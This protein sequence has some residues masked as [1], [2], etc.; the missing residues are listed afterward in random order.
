MYSTAKVLEQKITAVISSPQEAIALVSISKKNEI[1]NVILCGYIDY[2][3]KEYI[4]HVT[5]SILEKIPNI[6]IISINLYLN[7][8][9]NNNNIKDVLKKIIY[10]Y[11]KIKE[12]DSIYFNNLLYVDGL[13]AG[14]IHCPILERSSNRG[15]LKIIEHS[16][17]DARVQNQSNIKKKD[18]K[19]TKLIDKLIMSKRHLFPYILHL[20]NTQII[21]FIFPQYNSLKNLKTGWTWNKKRMGYTPLSYQ[22]IDLNFL[23]IKNI[24]HINKNKHSAV[25]LVDHPNCYKHIPL[26]YQELRSVSLEEK[27]ALMIKRDVPLNYSII[28][29]LHPYIIDCIDNKTLEDYKKS[30]KYHLNMVGYSDVSFLNELVA[31]PIGFYPIELFFRALNTK[32]VIGIYSSTHVLAW[33]WPETTFISDCSFSKFFANMRK[34]DGESFEFDFIQY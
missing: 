7:D 4:Y 18:D 2:A 12:I 22:E 19:K 32:F 33:N 10:N 29:K 16:P 31:Y 34:K 9:K 30:I 27:Y 8:P 1:K 6:R 17:L 20:I 24:N 28:C 21:K 13:L 23:Q 26:P 5:L 15:L 14:N 3:D 25:L 11:K